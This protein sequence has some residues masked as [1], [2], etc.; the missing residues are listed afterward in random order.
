[1]STGK[2]GRTLRV[3]LVTTWGTAC[4]I[5]EHSMMLK[6]AVEGVDPAVEIVPEPEALNPFTK[7]TLPGTF[8]VLHLNYQASLH[9]RWT[10]LVIQAWKA[11]HPAVPVVVT[12]HDT[13]VPNSDQCKAICDAADAVVVHE[14]FDDLPVGKVRYWRMGVPAAVD[15]VLPTLTLDLRL[16]RPVLGTVGFPFPWKCYDELCRVTAANGWGLLLLAPGA[17]REQVQQWQTLNPYGQ[18]FTQFLPQAEVIARL[19]AC[20]ATAFTYVG[21]NTGQSGAILQGIAARK[22]VIALRTCRQMRALALDP[23]GEETICWAETFEEVGGYLRHLPLG[24]MDAG[25]V[26]LAHQERWDGPGGRGE[27]YARLYRE[28]CGG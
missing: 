22:P 12:Y 19:Q 13:G 1:M 10:P 9:S 16:T 6:A 27:Q 26:A 18:G 20:D 2:A 17:T 11:E 5:A 4:G 25:I 15:W 7:L 21:H 8:D 28:V 14:P 23:L 24:R 3:L